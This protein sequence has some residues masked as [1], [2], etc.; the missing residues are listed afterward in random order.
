M[1]NE[2]TVRLKNNNLY[3]KGGRPKYFLYAYSD[4]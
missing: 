3:K 1:F 4:T 2:K